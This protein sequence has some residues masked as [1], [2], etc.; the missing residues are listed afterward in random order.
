MSFS[1]WLRQLDLTWLLETAVTAL[2]AVL[3]ITFHETC[4][5]LAAWALGDTTAKKQGRLSLNPLRH[6]DWFGLLMLAV[7]KFGWAKPVPIDARNFRHP[8]R[9][10]AL[11]AMAGPLANVLLALL[12]L[13]LCDLC[14]VLFYDSTSVF[15]SYLILFFYY[16]AVLSV[17]LA[18]FNL[19]PIPPL[20]GSKILFS[21]LPARVYGKILRYERYGFIVLIVVL[22][23]GILDTPLNF[24]RDGLLEL[25]SYPASLPANLLLRLQA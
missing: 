3:C 14:I 19:F 12:S 5:G 21:L 20:D 6:I 8:K 16:T 4:H 10:I 18:V 23:T 9:D 7:A 17:G 25:L 2:A 13:T 24:L 11:T 15:I 22:Y 1:E